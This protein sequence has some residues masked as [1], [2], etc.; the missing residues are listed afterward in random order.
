MFKLDAQENN[1]ISSLALKNHLLSRYWELDTD[2]MMRDVFL[3]I[4]ADE[5]HHRMV[6][7]TL[8]SMKVNDTNP[9]AK[10]Q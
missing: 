9:F 1:E 8:G 5:A 6:N 3:A 10:G 2:A 7:H 4:R